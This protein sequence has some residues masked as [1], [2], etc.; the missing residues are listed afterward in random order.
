MFKN[1]EDYMKKMGNGMLMGKGK[2]QLKLTDEQLE[3]CKKEAVKM[4][5]EMTGDSL[6]SF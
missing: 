5:D 4:Y 3:K 2:N 1:G 6:K